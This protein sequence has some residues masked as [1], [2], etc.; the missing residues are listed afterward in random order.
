[1]RLNQVFQSFIYARKISLNKKLSI[2]FIG[3]LFLFCNSAYAQE[4]F[5]E[6]QASQLENKYQILF[7]EIKK[8]YKEKEF[9]LNNRETEQYAAKIL[10]LLNQVKKDSEGSLATYILL[11]E[12]T[13]KAK[14][15]EKRLSLLVIGSYSLHNSLFAATKYINYGQKL[16]IDIKDDEFL[17]AEKVY[18]SIKMS[19]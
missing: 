4:T 8:L 3:L 11:N 13:K 2:S 14:D 7:E 17:I 6:K 1:M 5:K 9:T 18:S 19:N 16:F 12:N 10:I 15:V